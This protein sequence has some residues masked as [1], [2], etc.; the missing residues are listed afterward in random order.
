[1]TYAVDGRQNVVASTSV[2]GL[3]PE[4]RPSARNNLFVFALPE[5]APS[6][7]NRQPRRARVV[8]TWPKISSSSARHC[9]EIG[10][11]NLLTCR[12]LLMQRLI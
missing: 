1:M 6:L 8:Q 11:Q 10:S 2:D 7:L 4:L 9:G 3:T 5:L 12:H